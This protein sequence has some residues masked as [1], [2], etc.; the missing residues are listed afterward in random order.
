[1][2]IFLVPLG[3]ETGKNDLPP[4]ENCCDVLVITYLLVSLL[5]G[6]PNN[7]CTFY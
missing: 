1:M 3:R 7:L 4:A 5:E 6:A 2:C